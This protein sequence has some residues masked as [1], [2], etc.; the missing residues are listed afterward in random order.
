MPLLPAQSVQYSHVSVSS[1]Q[2]PLDRV[3]HQGQCTPSFKLNLLLSG[4]YSNTSLISFAK[5]DGLQRSKK[6]GCAS[7]CGVPSSL[8]SL[9]PSLFRGTPQLLFDRPSPA[10]TIPN[11]RQ[12]HCEQMP[13]KI[14][15][16]PSRFPIR[17]YLGQHDI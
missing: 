8:I 12:P 6:G 9:S 14:G 4:S 5:K 16:A 1:L 13:S 2:G 11:N 17:K 15:L 7:V 3:R 10:L